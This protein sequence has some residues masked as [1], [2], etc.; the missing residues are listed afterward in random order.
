MQNDA[1]YKRLYAH[2]ELVADLLRCCVREPWV[3][4]LDFTTL[5]RVNGSHVDQ[6]LQQRHQDVI[7]RLRW[8]G[9]DRWVYVYLLLEFQSKPDHW[10][11]IRMLNYVALFY[12]H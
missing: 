4:Q 9:T 1:S 3:Q 11:P 12:D 5:E 2:A 6:K 7:W 10:M 8:S